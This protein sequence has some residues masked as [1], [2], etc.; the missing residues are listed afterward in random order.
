MKLL[1]P[2]LGL[3]SVAMLFASCDVNDEFDHFDDLS[4]PTDLRSME[5]TITADDYATFSDEVAA[6]EAFNTEEDAQAQIPALLAEKYP[7]VDNNSTIKIT[8]NLQQDRPEFFTKVYASV[9]VRLIDVDY[10]A[11]NGN[12]VDTKLE[13]NANLSAAL[14][15]SHADIVEGDYILASYNNNDAV[16]TNALMQRTAEGFSSVYYSGSKRT[17]VLQTADFKV[18]GGSYDNFSSSMKYSTYL[19]IYLAQNYAYAKKGDAYTFIYKMYGGETANSASLW[20]KQEDGSWAESKFQT[21]TINQFLRQDGIW[22]FNP[23]VILTFSADKG[24]A[25]ASAFY[26]MGVDWVKAN[27]GEAYID[28]YGTSESYSGMSAYYNNLNWQV[29]K[30]KASDA[31]LYGE[32]SDDELTE[33]YK[34]HAVEVFTEVLKL[35]YPDIAPVEDMTVTITINFIVYG[36]EAYAGEQTIVFNVVSNDGGLV[37]ELASKTF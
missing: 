21:E 35:Q 31:T 8:Y 26:Q 19:P 17:I 9:Q 16:A 4:T 24:D 29:A 33:A 27:I 3:L 37:L 1:K 18:M 11:A 7:T 5:Y 30:L 34:V 25:A 28:S 2:I 14:L 36:N 12:A 10:M 13:N 20:I 22:A 23:S 15:N 32:M 6:Q